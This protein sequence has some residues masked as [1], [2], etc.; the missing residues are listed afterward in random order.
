MVYP[1]PGFAIVI[2]VTV[3]P[4][5]IVAVAVAV[6][7][8]PTLID[9]GADNLTV[10]AESYPVPAIPIDIDETVP[11]IDTFAVADAFTKSI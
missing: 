6:V 8:T 11:A 3:P 1:K 5:P 9:G 4:T 7:P 10:G 2:A